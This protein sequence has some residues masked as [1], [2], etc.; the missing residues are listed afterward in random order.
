MQVYQNHQAL[1]TVVNR[2]NRLLAGYQ[3]YYQN[4]RGFHWNI[5]GKDFFE[6]HALFEQWYDEAA[7][8]I[9]EIAERILTLGAIP[10]HTFED[11]ITYSPVALQKHIDRSAPAV[12]SVKEALE[13]LLAEEREIL[14][15]A[16]EN[17]D[18]G[19]VA[20]M[21]EYI[22]LQEKRLWMLGAYLA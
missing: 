19:T 6:M 11:Y 3:M 7:G 5:R 4:L 21:S 15:L 13:I 18:E 9:D 1:D 12:Q 16:A 2:M 10:L 14:K 20:M 8:H 17:G 22:A